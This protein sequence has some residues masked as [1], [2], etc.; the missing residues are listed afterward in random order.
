M[1]R[2]R[3]GSRRRWAMGSVAPSRRRGSAPARA[4]RITWTARGRGGRGEDGAPDRDRLRDADHRAHGALYR[5]QMSGPRLR[6]LDRLRDREGR[7]GRALRSLR[8]ARGRASGVRGPGPAT[9]R[10][11]SRLRPPRQ[12]LCVWCRRAWLLQAVRSL[13]E[14]RAHLPVWEAQARA[15]GLLRVVPRRSA[16]PEAGA[17][18]GG[19]ARRR[20][21]QAVPVREAEAAGREEMRPL[22]RGD[23]GAQTGRPAAPLLA[24]WRTER[25]G[26]AA[27]VLRSMPRRG[28]CTAAAPRAACTAGVAADG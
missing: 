20:A 19:P 25:A 21:A 8:A 7:D 23:M 16:G 14:V 6:R 2:S 4:T 22:P 15:V 27:E 28:P 1:C 17:G 18:E 10:K 12:A 5:R 26:R 13:L 9:R 11:M 24:V 3:S